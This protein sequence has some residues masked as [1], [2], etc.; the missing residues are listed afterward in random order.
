MSV[1]VMAGMPR[2]NV[3]NVQSNRDNHNYRIK[4]MFV[5]IGYLLLLGCV[6]GALSQQ[7]A[8]WGR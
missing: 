2:L 8:I 3:S 7:G 6:L 4:L 1:T 5:G